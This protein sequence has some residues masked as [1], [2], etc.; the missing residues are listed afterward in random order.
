MTLYSQDNDVASI[1][2]DG[3]NTTVHLVAGGG[4]DVVKVQFEYSTDAGATWKDIAHRCPAPTARSRPS[5]RPRRPS[6]TPPSR[7]VRPASTPATCPHRDADS[8]TVT[9][10]AGADAVDISKPCRLGD[11][12]LRAAVRRRPEHKVSRCRRWYHQRS[13]RHRCPGQPRRRRP[14]TN[15]AR[16]G[17]D[18]RHHR[19]VQGH[20]RLQRL[21]LGRAGR[22][23]RPPWTRPWSAPPAAPTTSSPSSSTSRRSARSASAPT[24][25]MVP[26][27]Q[28]RRG[29]RQG[30]RPEGPADRRCPGGPEDKTGGLVKYTDENGVATFTA[31]ARPPVTR[32]ATTSTPPT[33]TA[34]TTVS[35]TERS[36]TIKSYTPGGEPRSAPRRPTATRSTSTST[37]PATSRSWSRTRTAPAWPTR[38]SATTG[39]SCRSTAPRFP[40][41]PRLTAVTDGT[42][43]RR[44]VVFAAR[45]PSRARGRSTPT[46]TRTATRVRASTTSAARR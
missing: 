38:S 33:S 25:T 39:P 10:S 22:P 37:P 27:G 45:R 6:T 40:T 12:C 36:I 46:S 35:T 29:H 1:R 15:A 17:Q 28:D 21:H 31:S 4:S 13:D 19:Q 42:T 3:E 23:A 16:R 43:A 32:T 11:R 18:R 9:V 34:T 14:A 5:G 24:P 20:R 41:R 7:S 30:R 44:L 2:N 8:K 26:D